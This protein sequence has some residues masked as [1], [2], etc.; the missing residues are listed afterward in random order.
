MKTRNGRRT[1]RMR[2]IAGLVVGLGSS[3]LWAQE[4]IKD[5]DGSNALNSECM[6]EGLKHASGEMTLK[7]LRA[8]CLESAD[9]AVRLDQMFDANQAEPTALEN[10]IQAERRNKFEPYI[11]LP[12]RPN[13]LLIG[14]YNFATPNEQ[15]YNGV[16]YVETIDGRFQ[17]VETKFQ[18]SLKI[19]VADNLLGGRWFVAYTN[20]AFWQ[21]YNMKLSKP[22]RETNHEPELWVTYDQNIEF[23]GW[24]NRLID[25]GVSHQSNGRGDPI[26][27]SW[28][29]IY[30]RFIF[31]RGNNVI[32]LK[33]WWR[34]PDRDGNDDNP[35]ILDYMGAGELHFATK[36]GKNNLNMMV[37]NNF[38]ADDNY[39]AVELNYSYRLH[40]NLQGYVQWFYGYGESMIDYNHLNNSIGI[41]VKLNSWL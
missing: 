27:R 22:F 5:S 24:R 36:L 16:D 40:R 7:T 18:V 23:L 2:G 30:A 26:S 10:R 21:A 6:Q 15:P 25:L 14:S 31:E 17:R 4:A 39:G 20:R 38:D 37:R 11:M 29:R 33:P 28:N 12:Y 13:Y 8:R 19:P 41:G 9:A 32:T 35:D 34:I 1:R 3:T